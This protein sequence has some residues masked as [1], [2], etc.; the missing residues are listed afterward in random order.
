MSHDWK[1][2]AIRISVGL[3]LTGVLLVT[4]FLGKKEYCTIRC[5]DVIVKVDDSLTI[6]LVTEQSV[7]EYLTSEYKGLIG[8][9]LSD[10]DLM[11]VEKILD[12]QISI[13]SS[14]AYLRNNGLLHVNVTQVRPTVRFQTS[15]CGFYCNSKGTLIPAQSSFYADVPIIDGHIPIDSADFSTGYPTNSTA[16]EW[17]RNTMT[18]AE[19]ISSHPVWGDAISQIHCD[20]SGD[21]I[22]VTKVGKEK[23]I[24]G[25][26]KHTDAKLHRMQ[27]YYEAIAA[28]EDAKEYDIVDL[29]FDKQIICRTNEQK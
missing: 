27:L 24:F 6:R 26:P 4:Y 15:G 13:S 19:E 29:R 9:P 20:E 25:E 5:K 3:L 7:K 21:L 22:I 11:K 23:F 17:M 14:N 1:H 18:M 28:Q 10:I 12:N 2:T 16:V 8:M